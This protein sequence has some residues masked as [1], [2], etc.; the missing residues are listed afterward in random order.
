MRICWLPEPGGD[1]IEQASVNEQRRSLRRQ[2]LELEESAAAGRSGLSDMMVSMARGAL[3][4]CIH[5]FL[6]LAEEVVNSQISEL[7]GIAGTM[8]R[9]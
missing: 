1:Y 4:V 7:E 8:L 2:L 9:S 5:C 6:L 3:R